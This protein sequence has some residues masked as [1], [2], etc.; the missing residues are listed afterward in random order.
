MVSMARE[1][2]TITL[3]REKVKEAMSLTGGRSMS[4][5]IDTA[6]EQLIRREQLRADVEAYARRP[7]SDN[8]L[9]SAEVPLALDLG[10]QD[11]DYESLYGTES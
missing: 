6:L 11:E 3:D 1:K 4:D 7:M 9:A 10:D 2:A 5:V 8:E